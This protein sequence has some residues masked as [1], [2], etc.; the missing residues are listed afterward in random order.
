MCEA[1]HAELIRFILRLFGDYMISRG[2]L[3][4]AL[5]SRFQFFT[6]KRPKA[7]RLSDS[8]EA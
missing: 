6:W 7:L 4:L 5:N 1:P 3:Y 8:R 2:S